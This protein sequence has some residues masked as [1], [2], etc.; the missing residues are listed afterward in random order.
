[1][2]IDEMNNLIQNFNALQNLLTPITTLIDD[3]KD[4]KNLS[5]YLKS[6][7]FYPD[8]L[9]DLSDKFYEI[10]VHIDS[11]HKLGL[12]DIPS[13]IEKVRVR[14]AEF[15]SNLDSLKNSI[16]SEK[17]SKVLDYNSKIISLYQIIL[18]L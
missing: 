16:E 8:T 13:E 15:H 10:R 12:K 2:T 17:D 9:I 7:P 3:C 14:S 18:E 4:L 6:N 11:K 1:M 5:N